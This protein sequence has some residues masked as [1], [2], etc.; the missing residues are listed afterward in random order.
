MSF[1]VNGTQ[2]AQQLFAAALAS[3]SATGATPTTTGTSADNPRLSK[4]AHEFEASLMK[5]F[6]KPLEQ[7]SLFSEKGDDGGTED[8][9]DGSTSALMSYGTESLAMAISERGGFGIAKKILDHF[10]TSQATSNTKVS[11]EKKGVS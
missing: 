2:P 5:E 4:A 9:G 11:D 10:K 6:L 8:S 7:D 3:K 1:S